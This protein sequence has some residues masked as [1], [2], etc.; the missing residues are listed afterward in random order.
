MSVRVFA[1]MVLIALTVALAVALA[2]GPGTAGTPD[3][4]EVLDGVDQIVQ[5]LV[6][7]DVRFVQQVY[8]WSTWANGQYLAQALPYTM[9]SVA[10]A[11]LALGLGLVVTV[12]FRG[13]RNGA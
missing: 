4:G 11:V 1:A 12:L 3:V 8:V 13:G 9:M 5:S 7:S 10:G 2:G 6:D